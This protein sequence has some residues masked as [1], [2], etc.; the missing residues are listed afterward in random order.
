MGQKKKRQKDKQRSTK[1]TYTTKDR[2]TRTPQMLQN[3]KRDMFV[4][5]I[6]PSTSCLKNYILL[7]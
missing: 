5:L 7:F 6:S 4:N 2:G 1:H 3:G